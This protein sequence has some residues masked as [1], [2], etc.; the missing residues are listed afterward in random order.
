MRRVGLILALVLATSG[1]ALAQRVDV[2]QDGSTPATASDHARD[3]AVDYEGD[4]FTFITPVALV[5]EDTN[6]TDDVYRSAAG[7]G[8]TVLVPTAA[9]IGSHTF[10]GTEYGDTVVFTSGLALT[11]DDTNGHSD[12]YVRTIDDGA[13]HRVSVG[14]AGEISGS[15]GATLDDVSR[16]GSTVVFTV[17]K[18]NGP[19]LYYRKLDVGTTTEVTLASGQHFGAISASG[20]FLMLLTDVTGGR[21]VQLKP[22]F[23]TGV[24]TPTCK[25]TDAVLAPQGDWVF[26]SFVGGAGCPTGLARYLRESDPAV[27][28][29]VAVPTGST[30]VPVGA[31]DAGS[32]VL[33]RGGGTD[34]YFTTSIATGRTERVSEG[35]IPGQPAPVD[36]AAISDDGSTV[37]LLAPTPFPG[38]DP[39][40]GANGVIARTTLT[41]DVGPPAPAAL[42]RGSDTFGV[43]VELR[44]SWDGAFIA[45][46][47]DGVHVS[48][49]SQG[50]TTDGVTYLNLHVT[51]DPDATPGP[52]NL[53]VVSRHRYLTT[54]GVCINCFSVT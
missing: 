39:D 6:G 24:D 32:V 48:G 43:Q 5:P 20:A 13:L 41:P 51:V 28:E 23:T 49:G 17:T 31:D 2:D 38:V 34:Q 10:K 54:S 19:H 21:T 9:D 36:G 44:D 7:G 35:V 12:V 25:V 15:L 18:A 47:G 11:G 8:G 26:G 52:R 30:P 29:S 16:D 14:T 37:A 27:Y 53:V 3:V 45:G 42:A 4:W 46:L 33:W 22:T 40:N 1:C 50:I